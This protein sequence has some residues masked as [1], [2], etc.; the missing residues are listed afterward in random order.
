MIVIIS[1]LM[2]CVMDFQM[3]EVVRV[4]RPGSLSGSHGQNEQ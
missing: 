4:E 1:T 2:A 3:G